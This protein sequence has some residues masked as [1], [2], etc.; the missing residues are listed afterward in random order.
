MPSFTSLRS[1]RREDAGTISILFT[2]CIFILV[3]V[4]GAS[5]D[6]ARGFLART[7][8][9]ASLDAALL[10]GAQAKIAGVSNVDDAIMQAFT[11]NWGENGRTPEFTYS[12]EG[13]TISGRAE[14]PVAAMLTTAIGF[15]EIV[16]GVQS[17]VSWGLGNAE[18]VLALDTTGSMTGSKL[19]G[20]KVAAKELVDS[21]FAASTS[22]S[23]VRVGLVPFSNYVNVGIAN[24]NATW[25][26]VPADRT[27][28]TE[29]CG[30]YSTVIGQS[31]CRMV[32]GTCSN[33]GVSYPCTYQTCDY[34]YGASEYQ[35]FNQ[36][37]NYIWQGCVGS[38]TYPADTL[39]DVASSNPVPGIQ[40]AW[41]CPSPLQRLTD[42]R[43]L[44]KDQIDA[45]VANGETFMQ[46]GLLWGWRLLS[47]G[48]PFADGSGTGKRVLVLMTD[49][50]N[51]RSPTYPDH[52]GSDP[53]VS[54]TL[55]AETCTKIKA[56][57]IEIYT[58]AFDV[59]DVTINALLGQCASG[60]PHAFSATSVS[61]L[62]GAFTKIA[63]SLK[64][65]RLSN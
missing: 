48:A 60:P 54:N 37:T 22:A 61:E 46:P 13:E 39:A 8:L 44:V 58:V 27:E 29:S 30:W 45:M 6:Y 7:R 20:A 52:T 14:V 9:Q 62:V 18:V 16:A 47:D 1:F 3:G 11:A 59:T 28:T 26:S 17:S 36:T 23:R 51:T 56:A 50:A 31:N 15:K 43:Q 38:R 35:C 57:G 25:M 65:V 40:N 42:D 4:V 34:Q 55:T 10:A 32:T 19:D 64:S 12:F 24:R 63:D 33:D 53:T 49:G 41:G 21:L 5:L 2:L